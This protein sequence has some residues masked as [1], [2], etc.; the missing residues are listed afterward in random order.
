M[1][2]ELNKYTFE[3]KNFCSVPIPPP[4]CVPLPS[5]DCLKYKIKVDKQPKIN[6]QQEN[7]VCKQELWIGIKKSRE[8]SGQSDR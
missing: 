2:H 4:S 1:D 7:L 5:A 8:I 3:M 6:L